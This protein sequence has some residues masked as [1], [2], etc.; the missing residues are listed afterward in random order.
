MAYLEKR[1]NECYKIKDAN[2]DDQFRETELFEDTLVLNSPFTEMEVENLNLNTEIVEDLTTG[3]MCEYEQVVLDSEDEEMND[4][5]VG[6]GLLNRQPKS[7]WEQVDANGT[8]FEKSTADHNMLEGYKGAL[9]DGDSF[10][11]NNHSYPPAMLSHIHSPE[12]GDSTE[13][14]LG[15]VDQYLS[16]N[17]MDLFQGIHR[18]KTTREKSPYDVLSARGALNLAKKIKARTQ[19]EEK[20]PFKWV[21]SCQHDNKAGMF[22]KKIEASSNFG[23]YKQTYTRKRQKEGGH[24]Q[25]QGNCNTSNRCDER[26]RQGS[27][28]ATKNNNSPKELDV[29]PIA[30]NENVNV[31]SSVTHIE[32]MHDIGLDTQIA[33]EAMN[34][35]AFVPPSGCQFND[36]HQ[37]ENAL[38]GSL[39][40]LT[41]NEAR[42]KNSSYIQN[43][44]LHSITIKSNKKNASSS[45]FSKIT[46]NSA[47]K[48]EPNLV[49][50]KM[51]KMR[52]KS[53]S[54][55]QF[56]NNTSFT[57]C[58]KHVSLEEVC[59]LGEHTSFQPAAEESE[60]WN[61]ESRQTRIKDQQSHLT[62]GNNNVK[63]K[64]IKHKRKGN[65]LEAEPV[66]FGV[67]TR[68]LKF[69]TNSCTV[70]RKSR[71]NH[72]AQVSPQLSATS[73]FSRTDSWVYPKRSRGKRKGA[74]VGTSLDAPTAV[75]I[76]GKENKVF[77]TR[78]LQ[79]QDDVDKSC[80]PHT[81]P[82]CNASCADDGR[83]LLQGNFVP[84]G[85][86]GDAMKVENLPDM[87]PLLLAHVGISSNKSIAQS[88]S[89]MPATVTASKGIKV[90]NANHTY[91]EHQQK[92]C[93]KTLPKT[94][95][96]K[97]LIR[98]GAP[99]F[100]SDKMWKDLRHRRDM[101]DVRVLF[102]QHLD[103]S[104]MK[105]Q[106]KILARLNISV[107]SCSME[108]THFI[109]DKFTRTRNMLETM[110]LGKLVVNHLWLESCG[111]A[112]C[113][114]DE[115][116]YILRDMKKEKE[117]GFNM[118]V[119]LARARQKPLLKGKR[120][121]ITP[122]IKP[123]KEVVASLVTA[124]HAQVVDES[125]VC[126]DMNDN[127]FDDLLILSCEDDY[128]ICHRFLKRGTAVYSSE[129]VLNGIVIQKLELERH[130]LFMNQVTR[131]NPSVSNRFG[132]IYRRRRGLFS[133][134]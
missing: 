52:S 27:R 2:E 31:Y 115:K 117:I 123:D 59:S 34:A 111:Q 97:E 128:A 3:T 84:P 20:E 26:L 105:Q 23:R 89:E 78:S 80:F 116:N 92:L 129:L 18:G 25:G 24:L 22:G 45:R 11:D 86:A 109:A 38:D 21:E 98:L 61:N 131:N 125:E 91:T 126:A 10:D 94:S 82:L 71:L 55:G 44:D 15:F 96:L 93:E 88:R 83:C 13:A 5:G 12:P 108:A 106:K 36:T 8:T 85:S 67:W 74:N 77:S 119:S 47:C 35:L 68:R 133:G 75:C 49:S 60:D 48:Q 132:K 107:A 118:P 130:Q 127:V 16:S 7:P 102:S 79:D 9:V 51:K 122:H 14:A 37:P 72:L 95:V 32:D 4:R 103:D 63:E 69:P 53:S 124:V 62:E 64:G 54:E 65:D 70:A 50:W 120:V 58:S 1:E 90:S 76:D 134:P 46:F 39:S 30:I 104:I 112:N 28:M 56:E 6:K 110:A 113:F 43:P 19:N 33:A 121:Y 40:D 42:L 100:T 17:D 41:E 87:H 57:M 99:K 101:T 29:Q 66:K 73:S 81:R 114:I